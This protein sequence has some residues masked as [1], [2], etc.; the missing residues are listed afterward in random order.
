MLHIISALIP[1][2]LRLSP[3]A[4]FQTTNP[5]TWI[6]TID[7]DKYWTSNCS[8]KGE[9]VQRRLLKQELRYGRKNQMN[10]RK[11][12]EPLQI[13]RLSTYLVFLCLSSAEKSAITPQFTDKYAQKQ[14]KSSISQM[15]WLLCSISRVMNPPLP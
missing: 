13:G 9:S 6:R 8:R 10:L 14:S 15:N 12:T 3:E 4:R 1:K 7:F 5:E 2:M 11:L